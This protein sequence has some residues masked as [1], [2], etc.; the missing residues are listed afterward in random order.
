MTSLNQNLSSL[1]PFGGWEM[2][3]PGNEV[4]YGYLALIYNKIKS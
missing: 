3:D 1:T 4:G 2:K